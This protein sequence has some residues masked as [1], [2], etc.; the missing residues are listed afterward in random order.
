[1]E[2]KPLK[3]TNPECEKEF[4]YS[5]DE[6]VGEAKGAGKKKEEKEVLPRWEYQVCPHCDESD[7]YKI[8]AV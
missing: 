3:C 5:P 6:M 8:Q 7:K 4:D 1:M 2:I